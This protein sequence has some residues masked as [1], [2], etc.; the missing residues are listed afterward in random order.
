MPH[1]LKPVKTN[2]SA[3]LDLLRRMID[4]HQAAGDHQL[5]PE[6]EIAERLGLG[7]RAVRRAL[8]VLEAEGRIWR[9]QGAGTFLSSAGQDNE[10][11]INQ[12]AEQ[13]DFFGVMEARLRLEPGLAQLAALRATAAEV[14]RMRE[15][16]AK[17][18][19]AGD[20]DGR[21]LWDSALH[22]LIATA[23]G[24]KLLLA[25]FDMVDKV[26]QNESWRRIR[27]LSR[28]GDR[29]ML[30]A[31]QHSEIVEAI[32]ERDPHKAEI[33]MRR[34]LL[35][36]QENLLNITAGGLPRAS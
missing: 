7:R 4:G 18:L 33:A 24:N 20:A 25:L 3:A 17:I 26:R 9:R 1:T 14:Q 29:L 19:A 23:A 32:A 16:A 22:R 34:H 13:T 12:L 2:S 8:E 5:P 10:T 27:E 30:Y 11:S 35:S 28:S 15:L 6:R 36:L 21:E 31:D